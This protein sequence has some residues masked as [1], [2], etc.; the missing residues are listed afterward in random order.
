[1]EHYEWRN[2]S[3][4]RRRS[5]VPIRSSPPVAV[6]SRCRRSLSR[7]TVVLERGLTQ[8][9]QQFK[10]QL[11]LPT[12]TTHR[13]SLHR[14]FSSRKLK[15]S[16][17]GVTYCIVKRKHITGTR[18]LKNRTCIDRRTTATVW[19]NPEPPRVPTPPHQASNR[20]TQ[21]RR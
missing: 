20:T 18:P 1:M 19:T 5:W 13:F 15:R 3:R 10:H 8:R 21:T 14:R 7:H 11:N 6:V 2:S 4:G 17:I 12:V 16:Q 9:F